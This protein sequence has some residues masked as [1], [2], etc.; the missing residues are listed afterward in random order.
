MLNNCHFITVISLKE[1]AAIL[2]CDYRTVAKLA[3]KF[4]IISPATGKGRRPMLTPL[5]QELFWSKVGRPTHRL[6]KV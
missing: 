1:L 4:G 6:A 2:G 5:D 3:V